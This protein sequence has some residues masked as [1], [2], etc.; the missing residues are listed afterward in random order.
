MDKKLFD[1]ESILALKVRTRRLKRIVGSWS[2]TNALVMAAQDPTKPF[3]ATRVALL[4]WSLKSQ[5]EQYLPLAITC[6]PEEDGA[7]KVRQC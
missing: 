7:G 5:D 4:R 1:Q 3:P 6:W 2:F